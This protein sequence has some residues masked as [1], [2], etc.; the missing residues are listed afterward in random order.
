MSNSTFMARAA[1][2]FVLLAG[3]ASAG[4]SVTAFV[5][6]FANQAVQSG[7]VEGL[8]IAVI[9]GTA[10]PVFYSYGYADLAAKVKPTKNT[11][12]QVASVTKVFTTNLLGQAVYNK[13]LALDDTLATFSAQL[14]KVPPDTAKVTLEDLGDFTGGFPTYA[15]FCT[16][17]EKPSVTGCLPNDNARPTLSQ[18]S[19]PDFAAFFR[20]YKTAGAPPQPYLYSDYSL[21]LL[22]LLLGSEADTALTNKALTGW[23]TLLGTKLLKP[24]NL[25]NTYLNVPKAALSRLAP[26][27]QQAVA[28]ATVSGGAVSGLT[29]AVSG[30]GYSSAPAVTISGGGGS[31]AQAEAKI[32][33]GHV[34]AFTITQGGAGY[35][36]PASVTFSSGNA[37]GTAIIKNGHVIGVA[38]G[39]GG[40]Y[41][42]VPTVTFSGGRIGGHDAKGTV[43]VDHDLVTYVKITD[44]GSGYVD[45]ITVT[46]APGATSTLSV[47]IW[48]PAGA[49][50]SSAQ[51][52]ATFA[53]AALGHT[54]IGGITVP[55]AITQGFA[56]AETAYSCE[57][58]SPSL[59]GCSSA[60]SGLAWDIAH[61]TPVTITKDG[62]LPGYSSFVL[63]LPNQDTAVVVLGN[64]LTVTSGGVAPAIA[65]EIASA[66]YHNNLL[67]ARK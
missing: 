10:K 20:H 19:G 27:Y 29:V 64:T 47:P 6:T 11:L 58:S 57:G 39:G 38:L 49:L 24:L 12:F 45:P 55:N 26:G 31:G 5:N 3:P 13:S 42:S 34:S 17:G 48:A 18:Y 40:P 14:G 35:T 15:P 46:V 43:F 59:S 65:S 54:T 32:D 61:E 1:C 16:S 9:I 62:S 37:T 7:A 30:A 50:K 53:A 66:L 2:A 23:E 67:P 60:E 8:E 22:G 41:T 36:A 21:G 51:D 33:D 28:M 52:L 44:P 25:T 63:L 56:I 4:T